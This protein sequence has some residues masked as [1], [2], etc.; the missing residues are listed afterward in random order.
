MINAPKMSAVLK[1]NNLNETR[2]PSINDKAAWALKHKCDELCLWALRII[3]DLKTVVSF[4][5][6]L[7]VFCTLILFPLFNLT[8][9]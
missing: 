9:K 7:F 3:D 8:S 6:E 2:N 1:E 4:G 5:K